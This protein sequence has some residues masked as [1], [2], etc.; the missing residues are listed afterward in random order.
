MSERGI[1]DSLWET[2]AVFQQR[3][4]GEPLTT[5]E[6]AD[7]FDASRRGVYD[8]L[9]ELVAMNELQTKQESTTERLWWC[10]PTTELGDT[11]V[12]QNT[13]TSC[14]SST[15]DERGRGSGERH[16]DRQVQARH[17]E[18]LAALVS[19]SGVVRG[20]GDAVIDQST[21]AEIETVVCDWLAETNSYDFAWIGDIDHR[22]HEVEVRAE[23]EVT[24]Y[25]DNVSMTVDPEDEGSDGPT[26]RA[27]RTSEI[28]IW[29]DNETDPQYESYRAQAEQYGFRSS[30]AIPIAHDGTTYGV[31]NV[32]TDRPN[33]F[34]GR[35]RDVVLQL[36]GIV[37]HAIAAVERKRALM[38][39]DI[40][41]L[42]FH[43]PD[44][45]EL[46]DLDV[47]GTAGAISF[48]DTVPITDGQYVVFGTATGEAI[49][50]IE[51]LSS[52]LDHWDRIKYS[53][54]GTEGERAFELHLAD[55]PVV[56]A[57]ASV[58]GTVTEAVIDDGHYYLTVQVPPGAGVREVID[59]VQE[60][61]PSVEMVSRKQ[62][63]RTAGV[64][65][66]TVVDITEEL[67]DRQLAALMAA[68]HAGFFEWPRDA[69]GE[70]VAESLNIAA[71]TFHQHLRK[72][73]KKVFE[74]F[75]STVAL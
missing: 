73:E 36:G 31:L 28:Q 45:L 69:S 23:S 16:A 37:G 50:W 15:I 41:E 8:R 59:T 11:S 57:V 54:T 47:E 10:Q 67:T 42:C 75:L 35:E 62:K 43:V 30:A 53:D 9:L 3:H 72:A 71:P 58:G 61:Y 55:P 7:H 24:N 74:V 64:S 17:R 27:F 26:D 51:N 14:Q 12:S 60:A 49:E 25:L 38:T 70:E 40:V 34:T 29:H 21:R 46:L 63:T 1:S 13:G 32:Y 44:F 39:D 6:V 20:I 65:R 18:E 66:S 33:A 68:Y 56:S 19:L 5:D 2:L 52:R 4:P 48:A 22:T